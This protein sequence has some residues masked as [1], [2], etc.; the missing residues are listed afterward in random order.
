MGNK[1]YSTGPGGPGEDMGGFEVDGSDPASKK[2]VEER[3]EK[4]NQLAAARPKGEGGRDP[5]PPSLSLSLARALS[6]SLGLPP[7]T[8]TRARTSTS[9]STRTLKS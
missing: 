5:P 4:Q 9:T 3:I 7:H 6:V 8:C 2:T 1:M